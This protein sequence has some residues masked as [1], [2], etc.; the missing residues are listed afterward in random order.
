MFGLPGETDDDFEEQ[1]SFLRRNHRHISTIAPSLWFCYFPKGS[2]GFRHPGKYGIDLELGSL[3]W[4]SADGA[5]D[6]LARMKRFVRYTDLM[7]ELGV[8]SLFGFP[9]LPNKRALAT[10][11]LDAR[12]GRRVLPAGR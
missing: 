12:P 4:K 9:A 10:T 2:E 3:Y 5:N 11:Y 8:K 7:Q 1:L 6:Y